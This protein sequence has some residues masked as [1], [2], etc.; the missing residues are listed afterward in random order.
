MKEFKGTKGPW[1]VR[2]R[3]TS[4]DVQMKGDEIQDIGKI[5]DAYLIAA[6]PDLLEALLRTR[7]QY[8]QAGIDAIPGSLNPVEDNHDFINAAIAKALGETK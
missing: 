7:A 8:M 6:A 2:N 4:I 5:E 3:L 1:I